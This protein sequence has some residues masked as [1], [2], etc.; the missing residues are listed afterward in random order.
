[1]SLAKAALCAG[2]ASLVFLLLFAKV[3]LAP[4]PQSPPDYT[5]RVL[6]GSEL[7][8]MTSILAQASAST[9]VRVRLTTT[10]SF[11]AA[12]EVAD[13]TAQRHYD[14]VWFAS[15]D[16]FDLFSPAAKDLSGTTPI[17]S[18]PVVLAVRSSVARRLGWENGSATWADIAEA[19]ASGHFTFGMTSPV[20]ADAGLSGL[21]AAATATA[22]AKGPLQEG[23]IL[24]TVPELTGLFHSQILSAP[25]STDLTRVYLKE[26]AHPE[27]GLPDGI[28][29]NE[30]DLIA[31]KAEAPGGDPLTLVY[32]SN[33]VIEADYPLSMLTT[34][35]PAARTAFER[36]V[37][38]LTS[39]AVQQQ[40]MKTTHRR[41]VVPLPDSELPTGLD[42]LRSPN[43]ATVQTL[44]DVYLGRLRAPGRTIYVLDTSASMKGQR[45]DDLKSALSA[46]T[47]A[48]ASPAGKFSEFRDGEEVTFLPFSYRPGP[49]TVFTIPGSDPGPTL[50][51]IRS[52]IRKLQARGRTAIYDSLVRAYQLL[53]AQ[54]TKAPGRIDSIVLITDGGNDW[55]S[56][57]GEFLAYYRSLWARSEPAPVYSIAVGEAELSELQQVADVTGG[58]L[59]NAEQEPLSAL[60]TIV[61]DIR[62]YQ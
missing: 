17:M 29:D 48:G 55:G 43:S 5:L 58:T 32:P 15:D 11:I 8:D 46:L 1:M 14:A 38:Y 16:Y 53:Q 9:G 59:T 26:L 35:R 31:L 28:I 4:L 18:S 50:A 30:A 52:D 19:A 21:V 41:P 12:Q 34:A 57:L 3:A 45:L 6:A 56:G 10:D 49:P 2:L 36:L 47:G 39:A 60:E 25:D 42:V 27:P 40:I 54:D 20:T 23:Q 24:A 44:I 37:G 22:R 51:D 33:G 61:E 13:G 7:G 62:G